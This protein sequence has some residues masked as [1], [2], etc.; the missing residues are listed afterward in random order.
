M[1][2]VPA[3]VPTLADFDFSVCL[4]FVILLYQITL[5][6]VKIYVTCMTDK[7]LVSPHGFKFSLILPL[8]QCWLSLS[9]MTSSNGN[10]FRVTG[11]LFGEFTGHRWIPLTKASDVLMLSLICASTNGW[12]YNRDASDSIR[13]RAHYDVT[14]MIIFTL[15]FDL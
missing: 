2:S 12:V 5:M 11:P 13:H 3:V 8:I 10:I 15:Y 4:L 7:E 6:L 1:I 14:V 9:M